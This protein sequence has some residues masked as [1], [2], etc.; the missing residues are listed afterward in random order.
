MDAGQNAGVSAA[1]GAKTA[2]GDL[3][4]H[5]IGRNPRTWSAVIIAMV[6]VIVVLVV[7]VVVYYNKLAECEKA[8]KGG[9]LGTSPL[10][11][12]NTGGNNPMW[13]SQMGDAGWGGSMHSSYQPGEARV[14]GASAEG[15]HA[16]VVHPEASM[17]CGGGGFGAPRASV[18]A[19]S[20]AAA[21]DAAGALP[22]A[23]S[24]KDM[25][26]DALMSVMNGG[27]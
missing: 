27:V 15:G 19:L 9:F 1:A 21:L 22:A 23:G 12:L 8:A 24:A 16:L 20:E 3:V 11:N 14:Y 10:G 2:A 25:D 6:V 26:D 7:T 18:A 17:S 5:V 4:F 13:Q